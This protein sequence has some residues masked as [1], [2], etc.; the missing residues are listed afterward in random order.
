M[1]RRNFNRLML[2]GT[3]ISVTSCAFPSNIAKDGKTSINGILKPKR[4]KKGDTVGLIAPGSPFSEEAYQRTINN[5]GILGLK[6]K[7]AKNLFKKY[8]Y[9]AGSDKERIAD[10]HEMFSDREVDAIWCVRG[11]Y[12]T[13]RILF[14]IDYSLIRKNPKILIG[15]SDITALLQAINIKTG[16]ITFHGPVGSS[17][18]TPYTLNNF[19]NVLMDVKKEY[20]ISSYDFENKDAEYTS[21]IISKGYMKGTLVGGNLSLLASLA[22]TP[23]N[24][25]AEGK[26]VFI[27]DVGEKPYRV[28]RMLTQVIQTTGL[29]KAN[30]VLLGVFNDCEAKEGATNTLKLRETIQDRLGEIGVP[31]Y[32]G[33]SFGHI[34][35]NCTLPVGIEANFDMNKKELTLLES[36]VI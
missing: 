5:L 11:G 31:V 36:A 34:K 14:D 23:F 13:T 26:I 12:G 16:L 6:Y 7:N 18:L 28:D 21:E 24:I 19:K 20:K 32:Y 15:Y 30:G 9:V 29:R 1:K 10:I 35:N 22:G 4:L 3:A 33:F 17:E 25:N 8:G 27:E 2:A